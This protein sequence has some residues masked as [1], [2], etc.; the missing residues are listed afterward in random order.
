[1]TTKRTVLFDKNGKRTHVYKRVAA[2]T[3]IISR[4]QSAPP[5]RSAVTAFFETGNR[6]A[7]QLLPDFGDL[8]DLRSIDWQPLP[9]PTRIHLPTMKGNRAP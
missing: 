5:V 8:L 7:D 6:L 3:Q 2:P 4:V 9:P 1:M